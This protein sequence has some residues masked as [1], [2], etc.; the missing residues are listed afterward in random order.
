MTTHNAKRNKEQGKGKAM[1]KQLFLERYFKTT[2]IMKL[3]L[4]T[5]LLNIISMYN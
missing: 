5:Y 2:I 3:T 1:N 4:V